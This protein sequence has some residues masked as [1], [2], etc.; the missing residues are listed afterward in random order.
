MS[1]TRL[2][3]GTIEFSHGQIIVADVA[4]EAPGNY[5]TERHSRQGFARRESSVGFSTLCV[6][7]H[8]RLIVDCGGLIPYHR[9]ER[10]I[11]VPFEVVSGKVEIA[12]PEE[13]YGIRVIE[14]EKGNYRL[15]CGQRLRTAVEID[16]GLSFELVVSPLTLSEVLVQDAALSPVL[17]LIETAQIAE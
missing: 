17:P 12:G 7:G 15:I 4:I 13:D 5:W 6:F 10:V 9:Y 1:V 11:A 8:G 3:D 2:F 14:L 16:F